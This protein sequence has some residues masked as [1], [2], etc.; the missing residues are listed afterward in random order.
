VFEARNL[1]DNVR[2]GA[3]T[4]ETEPFRI[5]TFAERAKANQ[6]S[7]QEWRCLN[8]GELCWK[9]ETKP[10][11]GDGEFGI[12]AID[13]VASKQRLFAEILAPG[14]A[15]PAFATRPSQPGNTDAIIFLEA[16]H[17]GTDF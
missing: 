13:V 6:S 10:R 5:A 2:G 15:K 9:M 12:T 4:V 11:I 1:R 7:A 16:I 17:A 8:F 14:A 3:K